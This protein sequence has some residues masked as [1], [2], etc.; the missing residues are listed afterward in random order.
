MNGDILKNELLQDAK[1]MERWEVLREE[2]ERVAADRR[3]ER[4]A[5]ILE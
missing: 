2:E 5:K 1:E 4:M 3:K